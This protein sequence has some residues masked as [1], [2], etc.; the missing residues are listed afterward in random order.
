MSVAIQDLNLEHLWVL[1]PGNQD[2]FLE[3]KISVTPVSSLPIL[4]EKIREGAK[5]TPDQR[6]R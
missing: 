2:Y 4:T 3:E 5:T 1:Y 6:Q